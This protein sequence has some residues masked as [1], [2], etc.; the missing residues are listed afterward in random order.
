MQHIISQDAELAEWQ[1]IHAHLMK[2]MAG[3]SPFGV[4]ERKEGYWAQTAGMVRRAKMAGGGGAGQSNHEL[5]A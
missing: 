2:P 1:A 5:W 3:R 4:V